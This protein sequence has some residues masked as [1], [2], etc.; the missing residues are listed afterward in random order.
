MVNADQEIQDLAASLSRTVGADDNRDSTNA[1]EIW[2]REPQRSLSWAMLATPDDYQGEER[3]RV[4][5]S[6]TTRERIVERWSAQLPTLKGI[7]WLEL[8]SRAPQSLLEAACMLPSLEALR[9][10]ANKITD[11]GVLENC[12]SLRYLQVG[13]SSSITSIEPL[14]KLIW[15][16]WL[17]LDN[18]ECA[19]NLAPLESLVGLIGLG[20]TGA[21]FKGFTVDSFQPLRY[22]ENLEWLH[23]GAVHAA[24]I[25]LEP[26]AALRKLKFL[27]LSN[28]FPIEEFAYLSLH[29]NDSVCEWAQPFLRLHSSVLPCRRCNSN[30]KV[31]SSGKGGRAL[32]PTCD[33]V[34]LARHVARFNAARGAAVADNFPHGH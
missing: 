19:R 5:A 14:A 27:G 34:K 23:L 28:F 7:R 15:L 2:A 4:A 13:T 9:V 30:W 3:V 16:N 18:I 25:S 22:L 10:P 21:E 12:K 29:V 31:I 20:F 6:N 32:C 17:Q 33:S 11:L 26:L 1:R 24:D 8:P